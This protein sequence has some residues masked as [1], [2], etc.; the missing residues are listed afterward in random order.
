MTN[1]PFKIFMSTISVTQM[2]L[3]YIRKYYDM[4]KIV[5]YVASINIVNGSDRSSI[6][7]KNGVDGGDLYSSKQV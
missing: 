4:E 2:D 6:R 5:N 3:E 7:R 1:S